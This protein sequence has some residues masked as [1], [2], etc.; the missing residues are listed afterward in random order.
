[1]RKTLKPSD[2]R[3]QPLTTADFKPLIHLA[4]SVHGDG[5]LNEQS[6]QQ[7]YEK[8]LS[9]HPKKLNASY[10]AYHQGQLVGFR[11]TFAVGNWTIDQ[12]LTPDLWDI[13]SDKV[14]YFKCN[15][16]AK[17]YR[18]LGIGSTMLKLSINAAK[19]Q[20]ASAGVSHLWKQS[21]NNSAI[22]YF[23]RCGGEL[24]KYHPDKWNEESK[25]GY[26][27]ILCGRDCHCEAAEMIIYF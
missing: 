22:S 25:L 24:V 19:Q 12:W 20:G 14:C 27:C 4:N 18:G 15:T 2:I 6:L 3:Y 5:Y 10:V 21:P 9:E 17:S 26:D 16:V 23:T 11:I 13:S 1:M 8:G 7:W